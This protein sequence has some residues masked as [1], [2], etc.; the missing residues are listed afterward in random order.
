MFNVRG[1]MNKLVKAMAEGRKV[2]VTSFILN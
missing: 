2:F 1:W